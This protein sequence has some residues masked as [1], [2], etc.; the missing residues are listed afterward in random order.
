MYQGFEIRSRFLGMSGL[1]RHCIIGLMVAHTVIWEAVTLSCG[2]SIG[3]TLEISRSTALSVYILV[4]HKWKM[5]EI[6]FDNLRA[7]NNRRRAEDKREIT[8]LEEEEASNDIDAVEGCPKVTSVD[9]QA[10]SNALRCHCE[11]FE[12]VARKDGN[13]VIIRRGATLTLDVTLNT[14]LNLK[15]THRLGLTFSFGQKPNIPN[16]TQVKLDVTEKQMFNIFTKL[17]D[18]R[19]VTQTG[20][21][22]TLEVHVPAHVMV[23][24]WHLSIEASLQTNSLDKHVYQPEDTMYILFNPWNKDD[25]VYMAD[26]ELRNE[27]VLNDVGKIWVGSWHSNIGR[28]W[29]YGQF[30]DAVLP[31]C[32]YLLDKAGLRPENQGDVVSVSRAIS[33]MVNS[34]DE[35]GVLVGRWDDDYKDEK[36][37]SHWT[38]SISILEQYMNRGRPVKYGQCWVFAGVVNTVCRAL[39]IPCRPV[40]N[41]GSAHDSNM[42][43]TI[44]QFINEDGTDMFDVSEAYS[45]PNV[46]EWFGDSIWNFHVW[47]DAWM[48][49]RDLP[50]GYGGWQAID[51]TPQERSKG[52]YQCGPAS[53]VAIQLGYTELNYDVNFL[54]GTVNAD[55]ITWQIDPQEKLGFRKIHEDVNVVGREL[56][57]KAPGY[58]Y[59]GDQDKQIITHLYKAP[60]GTKANK[61]MLKSA[62]SRSRIS[63]MAFDFPEQPVEDVKFTLE[64][65]MQVPIGDDFSVTATAKNLSDSSRTIWMKFCS[66]SEYYTGVRAERIKWV[67]TNI[68]LHAG[69]EE[70]FTLQVSYAEYFDKLVEYGMIRVFSVC[71]VAETNQAWFKDDAIQ[72]KKPMI[73]I[74][75][76]TTATVGKSM[77]V[78]LSFTNPIDRP[79]VRCSVTVDG[80]G[81]TRPITVK[82]KDLPAKDEMRYELKVFPKR[83]GRR[84][85]IAAFNSRELVDITGCQNVNVIET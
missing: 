80:P 63:R 55:V 34:N 79:L 1:P 67:D 8:F 26:D 56:L 31:A 36:N 78:K 13:S 15:T 18:I 25:D 58:N 81:I 39:G 70:R 46:L 22:L 50:D 85:I 35:S 11:R 33:R 71:H 83:G 16:G 43:L 27:Y 74:E 38:G 32:A 57:T 51:A 30:D 19:L 60:E 84:T 52:I 75:L 10:R 9:L 59:F 44:D 68:T 64:D 6:L 41:M 40:T 12:L 48:A 29:N 82:L 14:P 5:S 61:Q 76:P 69:E 20:N 47:N 42:S 23:G 53:H 37:P 54:V 2:E 7:E 73:N 49:R 3:T 4:S 24:I 28:S 45:I 65:I 66:S 17:W 62:A 21:T 72:V 77:L